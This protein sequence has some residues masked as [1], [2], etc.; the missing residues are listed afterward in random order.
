MFSSKKPYSSVTVAIERLTS[1]QFQEDD[2]S[3]IPDL[4]EAITLQATGPTEA[5]RAIRKKL[6]YGN[7]HRQLRALTILDGL[8]Q[9]AG[10]KFQR[11]FADEPLLERLRVCA[12][13]PMSDK[14]V[15]A[16]CQVLFA[17]WG[18]TYKGTPGMER[19]AR[20]NKELP[21]R[22]QVVTQDR[23]KVL[24]ETERDPFEDEEDE[25]AEQSAS[26]SAAPSPTPGATAKSSKPKP[27]S[28]SLF[29]SSTTPTKSKKSKKV[30]NK[31]GP[32]NLEAEK[33]NMKI[34]I[35]ESSVASINLL[36]AM[37]RINREEE[38]VSE[39]Q[40]CVAQF[41]RCKLL[42]RHILRYIQNVES[43]EWLGALIQ[44][45]D[46]LVTS[47]MTFEQLDSSIDADSDSDDELA[48]Q[49]HAYRM[50]QEK[51]KSV[52]GAASE[53]AGLKL[54]SGSASPAAPVAPPRPAAPPVVDNYDSVEEEDDDNP[55][56]D[57]NALESPALERDEPKW[58][59]V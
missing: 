42:R 47:L 57:A 17:G 52:D 41:E 31:S 11:A 55:F 18:Q 1:D 21:K 45:N 44:A 4:V 23:S 59:A 43:E 5:A 33:G 29:A 7:V 38:R 12:T 40:A 10:P 35:A 27:S 16:R 2:L 25:E 48:E 15:R 39:N 54:G 30:K 51:G 20:L 36:N 3:G 13:S 14:E 37:Q 8:M 24:K 46:Q 50:L 49:A 28:S 34:N 9:N 22:K 53:L 58:R 32:F 19:I 6:K 26:R 56:G